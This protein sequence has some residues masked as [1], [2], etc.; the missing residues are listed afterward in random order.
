[1]QLQ[2][3]NEAIHETLESLDQLVEKIA[4][5]KNPYETVNRMKGVVEDAHRFCDLVGG[6]YERISEVT[7]AFNKACL[8][9]EESYLTSTILDIFKAH[10]YQED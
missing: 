7:R 6:A 9:K 10:G 3:S 8:Y 4:E 2:Y 5:E 1:M